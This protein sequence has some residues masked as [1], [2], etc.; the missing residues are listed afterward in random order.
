[1]ILDAMLKTKSRG[2]LLDIINKNGNYL[3]YFC[4][5]FVAFFLALGITLCFYASFSQVCKC[6]II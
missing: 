6:Y 2:V 1:M 3:L 5:G 4:K